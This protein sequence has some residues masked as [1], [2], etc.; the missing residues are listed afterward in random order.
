MNKRKHKK[1]VGVKSYS[2]EQDTY[3][4]HLAD[5]K[6]EP[7]KPQINRYRAKSITV[8]FTICSRVY[9]IIKPRLFKIF[10]HFQKG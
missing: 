4:T 2:T 3:I 8:L 5:L 6:D 1:K 7:T 10:A 9:R